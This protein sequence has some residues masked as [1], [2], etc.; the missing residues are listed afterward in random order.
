MSSWNLFRTAVVVALLLPGLVLAAPTAGP[1]GHCDSGV[2]CPRTAVPEVKTDPHSCCDSND[3]TPPVPSFG[4]AD[5]DCGREASPAVTA[6]APPSFESAAA[7]APVAVLTSPASVAAPAAVTFAGQP[8]P[9]P[10]RPVFL[11]DC[12]FLT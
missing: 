5:C 7:D 8:A 11:I 2:P 10:A 9:P 3:E 1:C 12:A 4:S 6:D